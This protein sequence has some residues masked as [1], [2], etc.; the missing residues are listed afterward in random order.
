MWWPGVGSQAREMAYLRAK[1]A[2]R[3]ELR[4][5][6]RC[7]ALVLLLILLGGLSITNFTDGWL[8]FLPYHDHLLFG[9]RSLGLVH[10]A[11]QGD[12]LTHWMNGVEMAGVAMPHQDTGPARPAG[13]GVVSLKSYSG[14]QPELN[15]Y[16]AA[17]LIAP[18][19]LLALA[20]RGVPLCRE[21]ICLARGE[22][23]APLFPPPRPA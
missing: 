11:H 3:K 12:Q 18:L 20:L 4:N 9:A 19:A 22:T 6:T 8:T 16:T 14:L 17:G 21:T 15:S 1:A 2:I 13:G 7:A 23:P 10:H 5:T